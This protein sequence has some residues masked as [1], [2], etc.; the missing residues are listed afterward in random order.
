MAV[1][2]YQRESALGESDGSHINGC[3]VIFEFEIVEDGPVAVSVIAVADAKGDVSI[4]DGKLQLVVI[5]SLIETVGRGFHIVGIP[6]IVGSPAPVIVV[7]TEC[8]GIDTDKV[9][10]IGIGI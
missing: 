8:F 10:R 1:A 3:S 6:Q 4:G 5:H 7:G 2:Q 9:G